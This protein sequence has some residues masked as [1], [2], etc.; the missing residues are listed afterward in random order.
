M[1]AYG[2]G[3]NRDGGKRPAAS[4]RHH[5]QSPRGAFHAVDTIGVTALQILDM[6]IALGDSAT[7]DQFA[8]QTVDADHVEINDAV[9]RLVAADLVVRDLKGNVELT[10]LLRQIR[11]NH[12]VSLADQH[13]ITSDAL[14]SICRTLHIKAPSR[15]QDRIDAITEVFADPA[16][17]ASI[18]DEL[19]ASACALLELIAS[20]A[21]ANVVGADDVGLPEFQMRHAVISSYGHRQIPSYTAASISALSELVG[22]GIL[23][24]AEWEAAVWIWREAWPLVDRPFHTDWPSVPRPDITTTGDSRE[25][26][27]SIVGQFGQVMRAWE[28]EPPPVLKSGGRRIGKTQVRA[29]AKVLGTDMDTVDLCGRLAIGIEL[30]L[31]NVMSESGRGRNRRVDQAWRAD[32]ALAEEWTRL[33]PPARWIRMI[34]EWSNPDET[35]KDEA[36]V[37]RHLV[38]WELACLDEGEAFADEAAFGTWIAH[39]YAPAGDAG[40]VA[41]SLTDLRTL[42]LVNR[43]DRLALTSIARL[44]LDNPAAVF[45]IEIAESAAAIVQADLTVIAPPDLQHDLSGRIASYAEV[46]S[47]SGAVISRLSIDR[48]T[49]AVQAG[50]TADEI[51]AFLTDLSSVPVADTVIRL[52]Q[53]AAAR[54]GRVRVISAPTVVIVSDPADLAVALSVKAA[55]LT[56]VSDTVAV[57]E[58][59]HA[60]V[61]AALDRKGLAPELVVGAVAAGSAATR[62]A[63]SPAKIAADEAARVTA[64]A[65]KSSNAM[66]SEHAARL[67]SHAERLADVSGRFSVKGPLA[68]TPV[69]VARL[70]GKKK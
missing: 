39:R 55:K 40:E 35:V 13:A 8:A 57:S 46:E 41:A 31:P 54:A 21:G 50:E 11:N 9:E 62:S 51:I 25:R 1:R 7:A 58:V 65:A 68:L 3:P 19:S 18:R 59:T 5:R 66:L 53:D 49:R 15:K 37:N 34:A 63:V 22:H 17:A 69:L 23:G 32:P 10:D 47:E 56:K 43:S 6:L 60:K 33:N 24:M 14:A 36:L 45:D 48:I 28:S 4:L 64:M 38:L 30:L 61:R 27:P 44:V 12:T 70:D 42:G 20:T 2:L 52:V 29:T 16:R 26:L 67:T